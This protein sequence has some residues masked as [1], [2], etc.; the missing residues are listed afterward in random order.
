MSQIRN[1]EEP[2]EIERLTLAAREALT[3]S[4]VERLAVTGS[5]A[6]ELIDRLNDEGTSAALAR[7][8]RPRRASGRF[9]AAAH[10][11]GLP[12]STAAC[13]KTTGW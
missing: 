9:D 11:I 3:D 10:G 1:V 13:R 6:L 7:H 2:S 4:M 5:N 12:G 8:T